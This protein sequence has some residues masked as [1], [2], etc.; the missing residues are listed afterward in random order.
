MT[1]IDAIRRWRAVRGLRLHVAHAM[2]EIIRASLRS[3]VAHETCET[4]PCPPAP[5]RQIPREAA[6]CP[7]DEAAA[8]SVPVPVPVE[9]E[10]TLTTAVGDGVYITMNEVMASTRE[11]DRENVD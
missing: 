5:P 11:V 2:G 10:E 3:F 8:A 6:A 1:D 9:D 4:V 7:S